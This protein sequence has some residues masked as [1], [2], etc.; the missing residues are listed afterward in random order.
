MKLFFYESGLLMKV[1]FDE[2]GF[3][4]SGFFYE[5]GFG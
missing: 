3:D 1:V 2:S 5:N 4:E